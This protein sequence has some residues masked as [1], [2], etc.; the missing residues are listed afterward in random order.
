MKS[1]GISFLFTL[2]AFLG[3]SQGF[4]AG[5]ITGINA[6]QVD[7]DKQ[8]GYNKVGLI[9]GGFVSRSLNPKLN[10]QMEMVYIG[11]G[12]KKGSNIEQGQYDYM[13]IKLDYIEVP[14]L[15]Q[16]WWEKLKFNV[17]LGLSFG[18]LISSKEED[19]F[20]ET[21]L[22]GPFKDFELGVIAGG[23]IPISKKLSAN[24]RYSYSIVPV[25]NKALITVWGTFG[26]SYNN[27]VSLNINYKLLK[28]N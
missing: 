23:N 5:V 17:D 2:F 12:S 13:R 3:Y 26:G 10:W 22:V 18:A 24:L 1:L 4:N 15:F 19:A 20:G 21:V 25:A 16:I 8:A 14:I 11:K 6:S 7:G 28:T 9:A 27:L